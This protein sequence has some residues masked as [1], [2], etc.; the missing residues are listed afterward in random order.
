MED[1]NVTAV[2]PFLLDSYLDDYK[3]FA[4]IY[5]GN[6]TPVYQKKNN[7]TVLTNDLKDTQL[8]N[9]TGAHWDMDHVMELASFSILLQ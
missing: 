3:C 5:N 1:T 9:S 2:F 4:F 8:C 6:I 7:K